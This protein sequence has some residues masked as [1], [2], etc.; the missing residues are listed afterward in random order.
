MMFPDFRSFL[1]ELERQGE[2]RRVAVEVDPVLEVT[3]IATRVLRQ[4]GP[5]LL[6]ERVRGSPFPLAINFFASRRRIELALGQPPEAIGEGLA[7][8]A[9]TLQSPSLRSLWRARRTLVRLSALR[10]VSVRQAPVQEVVAPPDLGALPVLHCWP[11]DAGRFITFGLVLTQHPVTGRRNLGVYRLQLHGSDRLTVHW[12]IQKGGGFHYHEAEQRHQ[13]L[14]VA[15]VLGGD[16]AL[17]LAAAAPLPEDLDE[18]LF[19]AFLRGRPLPMTRA[20]TVSLRVPAHAEFVLE[21]IVRPHERLPEGPFGDHLGHYSTVAPFPV[22]HLQRV[23]HRRQPIYP[24]AIVGKPPQE[25]RFLGEAFQ[26]MF[27]P[28]L[29]LLHPELRGLW[30]YYEAG[31]LNLTVA[32]VAVRYPKEAMKAAFALLGQGQLSLHKV[33]VLVDASVDPRDFRAV[34]R[35]IGQHFDPREDFTLLPRTSL[36]T[37]DFTSFELHLGSKMVLDATGPAAPPAPP[38]EDRAHAAVAEAVRR[39]PVTLSATIGSWSVW[40]D[41]LLAV[42]ASGRGRE[43]LKALLAEDLGPIKLVAAVSPDV[44]VHDQTDL[45]WGVFTRFDPARDVLF[46]SVELRGAWPL[47]EGPMGIDATFKPGYPE[48]VEMSEEVRALVDRRWREYFP[49][50]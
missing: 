33:L 17:L 44:D 3:E 48:P 24:A 2:L 11:K 38:L 30:A 41:T 32:A 50:A 20:Q 28:L 26:A 4:G 16:P 29:R 12:Q 25:D 45:L 14:E 1:N 7:Q 43:L 40:E 49:E 34:L 22:F 10:L 39:L 5:A 46:R 21:G 19:A 18:L 6:F 42:Q 9:A 8:L 36:D 47:Y 37:L 13:T 23:T 27:G 35:A 31:F 15:V